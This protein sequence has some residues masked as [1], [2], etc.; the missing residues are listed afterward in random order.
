[1]LTHT[2]T[3]KIKKRSSQ[4]SQIWCQPTHALNDQTYIG[5]F[6]FGS[7]RSK[8]RWCMV[9]AHQYIV[10]SWDNTC[11]NAHNDESQRRYLFKLIVWASDYEKRNVF[12]PEREDKRLLKEVSD[13][14]DY[15]QKTTS[16]ESE[17]PSLETRNIHTVLIFIGNRKTDQGKQCS[18]WIFKSDLVFFSSFNKICRRVQLC[19]CLRM[20]WCVMHNEKLVRFIYMDTYCGIYIYIY[21]LTLIRA[22]KSFLNALTA[23]QL[24]V[25][26]RNV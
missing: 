9:L 12:T 2:H 18:N 21:C 3:K 24:K 20:C 22:T 6:L 15:T 17:W 19:S 10:T 8:T 14:Y 23:S 13:K 26:W 4:P 1:M 7:N 11:T 5:D 25:V 16:I